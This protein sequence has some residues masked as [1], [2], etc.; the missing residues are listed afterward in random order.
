MQPTGSAYLARCAAARDRAHMQHT[1]MGT[2]RLQHSG[3]TAQREVWGYLASCCWRMRR[4]A[5]SNRTVFPLPVG[6]LTTTLASVGEGAHACTH[7]RAQMHAGARTHN[8]CVEQL[9]EEERLDGVEGLERD[10][11]PAHT[12]RPS[13]TTILCT[14]HP[15]LHVRGEGAGHR[16]H[17]PQLGLQHISHAESRHVRPEHDL[18]DARPK[19]TDIRRI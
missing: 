2:C 17:G 5:S 10:H 6:A 13:H 4:M 7:T 18:R 14:G 11:G 1:C 15:H 8:T 3:M 16:H 9:V 19:R 12:R